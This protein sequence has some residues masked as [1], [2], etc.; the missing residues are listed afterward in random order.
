MQ[1]ANRIFGVLSIGGIVVSLGSFAAGFANLIGFDATMITGIA[2]GMG[3]TLAA[4]GWFFTS[5]TSK[6]RPL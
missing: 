3:G 6:P 5:S 4:L 1:A 2:G